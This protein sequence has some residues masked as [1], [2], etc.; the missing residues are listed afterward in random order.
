[1]K[2]GLL[3]FEAGFLTGRNSMARLDRDVRLP[4]D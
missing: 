1:M 4:L 2:I 3:L